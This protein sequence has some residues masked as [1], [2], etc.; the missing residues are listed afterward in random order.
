[1]TRATSSAI[2]PDD[3]PPA[4]DLSRRSIADSASQLDRAVRSCAGLQPRPG[5]SP[6]VR[7]SYR[8][9]WG[10]ARKGVQVEPY[11][12]RYVQSQFDALYRF[13]DQ[14]LVTPYLYRLHGYQHPLLHLKRLGPAGIFESYAQQFEA[15][16]A[17]S[18]PILAPSGGPHGKAH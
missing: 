14:M 5:E 8:R 6:Q 10:C 4:A 11:P 1:V 9:S 12:A 3:A 16:R 7:A 2:R 15:I 17:E 18:Q 13:D